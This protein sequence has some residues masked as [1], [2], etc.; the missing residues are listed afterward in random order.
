[1]RIG[2][3]FALC[4]AAASLGGCGGSGD[5]GGCNPGASAAVAI[6]S[7]GVS[8]TAVC[9]LPAGAVTF[10]NLDTVSHEIVSDATCAELNTGVIAPSASATRTL[11]SAKVCSFHDSAAPTNAAF[12]GTIAVATVMVSGPGY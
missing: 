12:Q 7:T 2:I 11:G 8:P 10:T 1:M 3:A 6:R 4:T 9:V 5:G